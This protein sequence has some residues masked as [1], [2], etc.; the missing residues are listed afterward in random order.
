MDVK[1]I[2]RIEFGLYSPEEIKAMA[3]CKIDNPKLSGFDEM[4]LPGSV[5]DRRMGSID[6][7]TCLTCGLKKAC[8]GHF[9]YI[10]LALPILHPMYT[11]MIV[12]F[13]RCFCKK[14]YRLL[15]SE[16]QLTL[17]G[18]TRYKKERRFL[19]ILEK[20][21][22][23]DMC[24]H[25]SSPQPKILSKAKTNSIVK[26]H[27][28]KKTEE[29][30]AKISIEILPEEIKKIF[31]NILDEDV[32]MLGFD[33]ERI[34]PRNLVL[35]VL[36][37]LPPCSR[38][39]VLADGNTCDDDLTFQYKEIVN[40]NNQ[41]F[42]KDESVTATAPTRGKNKPMTEQDR[43]KLIQS[44]K[45]K[46]LTMFNNKQGKAKRPTDNRP[47]KSLKD[48]LAGK[49]GRIRCNL[50]GKRVNFSAR[51]VIDAGPELKLNQVAIPFEV[52]RILTKPETVNRYNIAWLQE[53]VNNNEAN[54]IIKRKKDGTETRINL[55]YAMFRR[56][57]D[58]LYG[59]IIVRGNVLFQ[60][61]KLG[62][63]ILPESEDEL[64]VIHISEAKSVLLLKGDQ[65]IRKKKI[66]KVS[67]NDTHSM[68]KGD[69]I[70]R[71]Y[72]HTIR[73]STAIPEPHGPIKV[74]HV[75]NSNDVT[76]KE[77]DQLVRD[78]KLVDVTYP[79][80]KNIKLCLGD[81]VERHLRGP[82]I[83]NGRMAP[84]DVVLFN[85]Q[86]TLHKGSM[87]AKEVVPGNHKSFRFN[88]AATKSFNADFDGD[89]MNI[90]VPQ[91]YEAE[92]E[93]R[94]LSATQHNM[95]SGQESKPN[96]VIVQDSLLAAYMMTIK[97]EKLTSDQFHD[98]ASKGT[99][100]DGS[101]LW[102]EH[103]KNHIQ[104]ILKKHGKDPCVYNGRGLISLILP[105]TLY[106]EN[107]NDAHPNEPTVK[108]YA[109]VLV[110]G[111]F[112]KKILGGS[113]NSLI[114]IIHK[115]YG[116]KTAANFIDNVQFITNNWLIIHGFTVGLKDCMITSEKSTTAIKDVLA[117]CYTKAQ[118]IEET[119]QNPGIC[120]V[121]VTAALNEAKDIGMRIATEA[122]STDNNFLTTV[123]SGAKG[124]FFNIAQLTSL[125]GQ[126]NLEGCRVTPVLNHGRRSLPHY[127]FGELDKE[128][129]YESRGFVRHSFIRGLSPEEFYFHAM[130]GREG[131]CDTAMGTAKSGYIQRR[132]VKVCEDIQVRYDGTV[133]DAAGKIYQFAYGDNNLDPTQ[134]VQVNGV[135][136][137]CDIGR[138]AT[139]LNASVEDEPESEDEEEE[140]KVEQQVVHS[141]AKE[142]L[143][144]KIRA[145]FPRES[146]DE[147]WNLRQLRQRLQTLQLANESSD[148]EEDEN[149]DEEEIMVA[150][151][152]DE[153]DG[154]MS[155]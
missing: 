119:T 21:E 106:Y 15:L 135:Q 147:T 82:E 132:I 122:M 34:R 16:E 28:Q 103:R 136:Q 1:D 152:E 36:P 44:L 27:K 5:Y 12:A 118:A 101:P 41:L 137:I 104:R 94:M 92:V 149:S 146:I 141:R 61:D 155:D 107:K 128:R 51:T 56:G 38:P 100:V 68:K 17:A 83:R 151:P 89:E 40:I 67:K 134:T 98:V 62:N 48:R 50:M 63:V 145:E 20:L 2:S 142:K 133:R 58:L 37:V 64:E 131:I 66:V 87:M 75:I 115:E 90:H 69:I 47:I 46:I 65:V 70:V 33:P 76:L 88:L 6:F 114:Q 8:P 22:K 125:L 96:I 35:T 111:A 49:K 144:K 140:I 57:T 112:N 108:I 124:D 153:E 102:N 148:E 23:N 14:C 117:K 91:S 30:N 26:E 150:E 11:K 105:N 13:L 130:S 43:Q 79:T 138:I 86:P 78:G 19:K 99:R 116:V 77:G 123:N 120:E 109:G 54:F 143:I 81:V 139:R 31:D 52:A 113:H 55:R 73:D 84:G 39:P 85:R 72:S 18:L 80:P 53:V 24:S 154:N 45:F 97:N 32:I 42:P 7:E 3:V 9:G 74:I 10:E 60:E 93:L 71:G 4:P 121:R 127:P 59:D 110:E 29:K 25:C 129:D 126:Q 95:I